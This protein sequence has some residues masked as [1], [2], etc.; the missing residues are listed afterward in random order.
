MFLLKT[1]SG[2]R[3]AKAA[4]EDMPALAA[5]GPDTPCTTQHGS[6]DGDISLGCE[7]TVAYRGLVS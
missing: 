1:S 3:C 4:A 2:D 7:G 5:A 6:R